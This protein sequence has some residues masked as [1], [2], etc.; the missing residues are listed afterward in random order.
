[1]I[2]SCTLQLYVHEKLIIYHFAVINEALQPKSPSAHLSY[3]A[4]GNR[5]F[6][7]RTVPDFLLD[8]SGPWPTAIAL[9]DDE[10]EK[11]PANEIGRQYKT[12]LDDASTSEENRREYP[13]SDRFRWWQ[14]LINVMSMSA[15]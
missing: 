15:L 1:M 5:T 4:K 10:R 2:R 14:G 6:V 11:E 3:L 8:P 12:D 7:G 9:N 13:S